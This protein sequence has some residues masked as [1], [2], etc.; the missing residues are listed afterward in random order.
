[1]IPCNKD[2][3]MSPSENQGSIQTNIPSNLEEINSSAV[4]QTPLPKISEMELIHIENCEERTVATQYGPPEFDFEQ[5]R[6]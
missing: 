1:M 3:N 4:L 6:N 2:F 5:Y